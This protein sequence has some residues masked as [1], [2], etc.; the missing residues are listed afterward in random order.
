M[1][2]PGFS[3]EYSAAWQSDHVSPERRAA[4]RED[5]ADGNS[6]VVAALYGENAPGL[7][8]CIADCMDEGKT[9]AQCR[10]QCTATGPGYVCTPQDNSV[11]N[12]ICT[13]AIDVWDAVCKADCALLAPVP[14]FGPAA[15]AACM[16]G[17]GFV[18]ATSKATCPP[19]VICV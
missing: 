17:C 10:R 18:T 11:N 14:V 2:L 16:K 8:G 5:P 9:A 4:W 19:A 1:S 12:A 15:V 7:G 3:G 13:T 6:A